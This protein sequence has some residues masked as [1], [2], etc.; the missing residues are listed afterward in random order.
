MK[1]AKRSEIDLRGG[2]GAL[3]T[4]SMIGRD[5]V[6]GTGLVIGTGADGVV[7]FWGIGVGATEGFGDDDDDRGA[8]DGAAVA[9]SI[10]AI[11]MAGMGAIAGI[12]GGCEGTALCDCALAI[13][14]A[15][16]TR[17]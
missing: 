7:G 1:P 3:G 16:I 17:W 5:S 15:A 13:R 9:S 4:G 10:D 6:F 14:R 11:G 8:I 2:F 12:G